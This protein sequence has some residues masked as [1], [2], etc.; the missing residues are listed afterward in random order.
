MKALLKR[1]Y[2]FASNSLTPCVARGS[3]SQGS[4]DTTVSEETLLWLWGGH[5]IGLFPRNPT[6]YN[7]GRSWGR[8]TNG[9]LECVLEDRQSPSRGSEDGAVWPPRGLQRGAGRGLC[10]NAIPWVCSHTSGGGAYTA[11]WASGPRVRK[12]CWMQIRR[13]QGQARTHSTPVLPS[14]TSPDSQQTLRE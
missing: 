2:T 1:G 5:G 11:G 14:T 4:I 3:V 10:L 6:E 7:C 8:G 13:E 12:K 9:G